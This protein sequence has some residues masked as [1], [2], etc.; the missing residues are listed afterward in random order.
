MG[1]EYEKHYSDDGFWKKLG[2]FA[3]AAGR[4]VV[5]IALVL[6]YTAREPGIPLWAKATIY[7]AL[8][9]FILP[10]DLIPDVIP[11]AGYSDDLSALMLAIAVVGAHITPEAR[12]QAKRKLKDWFG[13]M[14]G[15]DQPPTSPAKSN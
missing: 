4:K 6:Y 2:R 14:D 12:L 11:G 10:T 1:N 5:E 8:G 13:E 15:D 7:S 3:L 9:Y